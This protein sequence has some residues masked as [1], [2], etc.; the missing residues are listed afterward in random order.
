[1]S[2]MSYHRGRSEG[3]SAGLLI[4]SIVFFIIS[5]MYFKLVQPIINSEG[6]Y[7]GWSEAVNAMNLPSM[8][9]IQH[10]AEVCK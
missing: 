5:M 8:S 2:D 6:Y 4:A 7:R 3:L 9:E 10:M 1:M